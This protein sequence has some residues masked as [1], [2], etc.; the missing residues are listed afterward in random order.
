MQRENSKRYKKKN[1]EYQEMGM[2]ASQARLLTLTARMSDLELQMQQISNSKIRLAMKT[3][4]VAAD[5]SEALNRKSLSVCDGYDSNGNRLYQDLNYDNLTGVNSPL[6]AQ[7]CLSDNNGNVLVTQAQA[8]AFE[9]HSLDQFI[10]ALGGSGTTHHSTGLVEPTTDAVKAALTTL[11]ACGKACVTGYTTAGQWTSTTPGSSGTATSSPLITYDA[12][13]I[14]AY[15]EEN[16]TTSVA[17]AKFDASNPYTNTADDGGDAERFSY[18]N[19]GTDSNQFVFAASYLASGNGGVD[20]NTA[21]L[22]LHDLIYSVGEDVLKA[23][24][25]RAESHLTVGLADDAMS[26]AEY[27]TYNQF[28]TTQ[29]DGGAWGL[30]AGPD[31]AEAQTT[32][33]ISGKTGYSVTAGIWPNTGDVAYAVDLKKVVEALLNNFNTECASLYGTGATVNAPTN[34]GSGSGVV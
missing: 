32:T 31:R 2:S 29:V 10:A 24:D 11:D 8:R 4:E 27:D 30:G 25:K 15:L 6:S 3:A 33:A 20:H 26:N 7:Y 21:M 17:A 1:K 5:Y 19:I 9:G 28:S 34:T 16:S 23:L 12:K 14:Y 18:A 22:Q 13:N